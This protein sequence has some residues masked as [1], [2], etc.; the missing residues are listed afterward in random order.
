[1]HLERL[2][3]LPSVWGNEYL[4]EKE[5][6]DISLSYSLAD[7]NAEKL[8]KDCYRM[9]AE[10]NY[11]MYVFEKNLNGSQVP[12]LRISV[13]KHDESQTDLNFEGVVYFMNEGKGLNEGHRFIYDGGEGEFLIPLTTSPYWSYS[14]EI[15]TILLDFI[16]TNLKDRE[17]EI[18]LEFEIL[19]S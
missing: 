15:Q 1:M 6:E 18:S 13:N 19:K 10:E 5:T 2:K 14:D 8:G 11:F 3:K 12:F 9:T 7:T 16:G 17:V 4:E